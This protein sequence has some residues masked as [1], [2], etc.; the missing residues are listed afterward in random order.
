MQINA[1][2]RN[3]PNP[4]SEKSQTLFSLAWVD[5]ACIQDSPAQNIIENGAVDQKIY[6]AFSEMQHKLLRIAYMSGSGS[7]LK[8]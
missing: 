3:R 7:N 2:A 1:I 6:E 4:K 8:A 5:R